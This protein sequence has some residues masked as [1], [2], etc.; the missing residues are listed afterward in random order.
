MLAI[1]LCLWAD[2]VKAERVL[3]ET[4]GTES[5]PNIKITLNDEAFPLCR[6]SYLYDE[7]NKFC[8]FYG[9]LPYDRL[10]KGPVYQAIVTVEN[11]DKTID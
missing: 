1:M 3:E 11:T 5:L 9:G 4:S 7:K 8:A 2:L 6:F 10:A